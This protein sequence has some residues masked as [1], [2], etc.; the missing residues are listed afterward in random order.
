MVHFLSM[1]SQVVGT[2]SDNIS[3]LSGDE[4]T[5]GVGYETGETW[6]VVWGNWGSWGNKRSSMSSQVVSAG[7]DNIG[8][9]SWD[10]G[11]VGVGDEWGIWVSK[12][13]SVWVTGIGT[14]IGTSVWVS[15]TITVTGISAPSSISQT[16]PCAI[17][18]GKS[19]GGKV[20]SLSSGDLWGLSWG[21][22]TIGVGD[23]LCAGNSDA[24]EENQEFHV[25][26]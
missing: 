11:T 23:E 13:S 16:S 26:S 15:S 19:L 3:G 4:S 24:S 6:S 10:Y 14:S 17:A 8:G 2:G 18:V 20:S 22:G 12:M 1:G 25:C 5:V 21:Y 7:S 9:L